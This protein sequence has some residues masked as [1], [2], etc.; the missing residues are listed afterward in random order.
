M[1]IGETEQGKKGILKNLLQCWG[2]DKKQPKN[3]NFSGK[4]Y[5]VKKLLVVFN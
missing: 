1:Y 4:N 2:N 5:F 3:T